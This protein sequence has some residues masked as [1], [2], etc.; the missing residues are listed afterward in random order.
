MSRDEEE[1][2]KQ[3]L[4]KKKRRRLPLSPTPGPTGRKQ[5]KWKQSLAD[6]TGDSVKF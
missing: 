3:K 5:T 6:F 2:K 4:K 1:R